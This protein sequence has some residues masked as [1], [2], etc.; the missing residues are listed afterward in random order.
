MCDQGWAGADCSLPNCP[1]NC[2]RA[3]FCT[4][5]GTCACF[6]G[7]AGADCSAPGCPGAG[8]AVLPPSGEQLAGQ[9]DAAVAAVLGVAPQGCGEH[10]RW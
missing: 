10:G 5:N 4:A 2:S 3:G 6:A 1:G 8:R 9:S 7:R